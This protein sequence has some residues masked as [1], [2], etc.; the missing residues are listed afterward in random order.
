M[1][2][3]PGVLPGAVAPPGIEQECLEA[4]VSTSHSQKRKRKMG[5]YFKI[6]NTSASQ[7]HSES[8][9]TPLIFMSFIP[10]SGPLYEGID[11]RT[12]HT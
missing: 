6:T 11:A 5:N 4:T 7:V 2:K 10:G 8:V 3:L 9:S 12:Q 1:L